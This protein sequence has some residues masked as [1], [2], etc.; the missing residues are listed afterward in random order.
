ME[1]SNGHKRISASLFLLFVMAAALSAGIYFGGKLQS[2]NDRRL[3]VV[4][5]DEK[6]GIERTTEISSIESVHLARLVKR[7]LERGLSPEKIIISGILLVDEQGQYSFAL[8][9]NRSARLIIDG[10]E[11][12]RASVFKRNTERI[13]RIEL[14]K[15]PCPFSIEFSP[16]VRNPYLGLLWKYSQDE[17]FHSIAAHR[18]FSPDAAEFAVERFHALQAQAKRWMFFRNAGFFSA[19]AALTAFMILAFLWIRKKNVLKSQIQVTEASPAAGRLSEI[20]KTKGFAGFLM[21]AAH[22]TSHSL[23]PFGTFG[24]ALFFLCSGMNTILFLERTRKKKKT[25]YYHLFFGILLFTGGYTQIVIAHPGDARIMP[26]FLQVSALSILLIFG[27]SKC[28]KQMYHA[29]FLFP[30]PF[31]LHFLFM[32]G[33]IRLPSSAGEAASFFFGSAGFPLFPWAGFFLY[34]VF[35]LYVLKKK[36]VLPFLSA[37]LGMLSAVMILILHIPIQKWGMSLSYIS[38]SLFAVTVLFAFFYWMTVKCGGGILDKINSV[39]EVVGRNSLM[40]VYVHYLAVV[41]IRPKRL[42]GYAYFDLLLS[43]LLAFLFTAFIVF[44][45]ERS[46]NDDALFI[47]MVWMF[48]LM[49]VIRY[50]NFLSATVNPWWLDIFIGMAFAFLYVKLRRKLRPRQ[51]RYV[52]F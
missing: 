5:A 32:E 31:L 3:K 28:F 43:A 34:G 20:D 27:L 15:G 38:L 33:M 6:S 46:K 18:I 50:G 13:F 45:Y 25:N 24:A 42:L 4:F 36:A 37:A 41:I 2:Q 29:G 44:Y 8:A 47:P 52:P 11:A 39:L 51:A 9:A 22:I 48:T 23:L 14:K 26:E 30:V 49:V 19:A 10:R 40:F 7:I 21:I 16:A 35:L 1:N 12:G 17:P